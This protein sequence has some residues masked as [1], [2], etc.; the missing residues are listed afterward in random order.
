LTT[1]AQHPFLVWRGD[2]GRW[3]D[4]N[5]D[6][7]V[8]RDWWRDSGGD[9]DEIALAPAR[10]I[11]GERADGFADLVP[12]D[13]GRLE[14]DVVSLLAANRQRQISCHQPPPPRVHARQAN[15]F[16]DDTPQPSRGGSIFRSYSARVNVVAVTVGMVA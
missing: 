5:K 14:L 12:I 15:M 3:A 11:V 6:P 8:E 7:T 10:Q 9:G 16:R 1:L 13:D 4:P 2:L